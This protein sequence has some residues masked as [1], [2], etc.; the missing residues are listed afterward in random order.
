ML[1]P[2]AM[3]GWRERRDFS[4]LESMGV[5]YNP[6]TQRNELNGIGIAELPQFLS[7]SDHTSSIIHDEDDYTSDI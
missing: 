6:E 2:L 7:R 5:T 4:S 1:N 3:R